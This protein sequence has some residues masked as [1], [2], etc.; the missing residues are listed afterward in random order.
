MNGLIPILILLPLASGLAIFLAGRNGKAMVSF[1]ILASLVVLLLSIGLVYATFESISSTAEPLSTVV[2][3]IEFAP[4][5]LRIELPISIAGNPI[6]WQLMFGADGIGALMV[7]LTGL[8]TVAVCVFSTSQIK[9]RLHQYIALVL[10]TESLLLGVFLAMD[11]VSFYIFFE[12][13]LLPVILLIVGWGNPRES[14]AASK[15]F[16]LFTLVG[17]VPMVIA[18]IGLALQPAGNGADSTVSF[19]SLSAMAN[20]QQMEMVRGGAEMFTILATN[21]QWIVW[22]LLLGFGIKLAVLPLHTWLPTTYA[23]AH[24]N[25]TALIASVVAKLGVFGIVRI[26]LPL[27]PLGLAMEAQLLFGAL[28]AIA[29]VYGALVALAQSDLR[30]VFAYSSISHMGFVTIGLMS[31]NTDGIS[32][33]AI[34]M[35]NHGVITCSMFLLLGH[36]EQ[37]K[38]NLSFRMEDLGMAALYPR[39]SVLLI[40]FTLAGA[41]LPGLNG[42]VGELLSMMG[43]TRVSASITALAVLGTVLGAWYALRIVQRILFGSDGQEKTVYHNDSRGDLRPAELSVLLGMALLCLYIG[44][45]PSGPMKLIEAD[46]ARLAKV[47]EPASKLMHPS[48]DTLPSNSL[49]S[50]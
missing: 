6:R 25:T 49:V 11:L 21:Q 42:F 41:G 13:V 40:F 4:S 36:L 5:W 10:I 45:R 44:V 29:I 43:M 9:E 35:F 27:T 23:A 8:V 1:G 39:L 26:V 46:V 12:A 47:T 50:N 24:P 22:L 17:S 14:L 20:Q 34:Q 32:G 19:Q 37:R 7:F 16:L 30:K 2:P 48:V 18:L 31:L 15:K 28:G 33:A 3:A 38:T